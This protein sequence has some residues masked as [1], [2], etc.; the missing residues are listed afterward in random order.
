MKLRFKAAGWPDPPT[1]RSEV[2]D[3]ELKLNNHHLSRESLFASFNYCKFRRKPETMMPLLVHEYYDNL[4]APKI[5][6]E[7]QLRP[8]TVFKSHTAETHLALEVSGWQ[9]ILIFEFI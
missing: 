1:Q 3:Q 7:L 6:A 4:H 2:E 8:F 5:T 9:H